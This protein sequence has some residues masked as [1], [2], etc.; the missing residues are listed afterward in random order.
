MSTPSKISLLVEGYPRYGFQTYSEMLG[1]GLNGL[2]ISRLHP[3][4]MIE[5]FGLQRTKCYWLSS[6]K[7]EDILS[8][9]SL[10]GIVKKMK[11][12]LKGTS[13]RLVFFDGLEYLLLWNDIT[14]IFAML[15]QIDGLLEE[16]I[17]MVIPVDP[18]TLERKDV[19]KLWSTYP[20]YGP[21]ELVALI[22]HT[23][24][25][26]ISSAVPGSECRT[27]GDL[28]GPERSHAFP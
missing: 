1:Y 27:I 10:N 8:P 11:T 25:Q 16:H 20:R 17:G 18:L 12:E 5:K 21:S 23:G 14:K 4:Y 24:P 26:R 6:Q 13:C 9:K 3:E 19:E 7:G 22:A 15:D 2:C 28:R